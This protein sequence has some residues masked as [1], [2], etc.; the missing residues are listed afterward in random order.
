M[1]YQ[2]FPNAPGDSD[3]VAKL[4]ALQLG[5]L[6]GRSFLDVACNEGFF[7]QEAWRRGASRVVGIDSNPEFIERARRKDPDTDYRVMDWAN[8]SSLEET[9]DVI[10]LL[11]ALHYAAQPEKLLSDIVD[12]LHPDG[13]FILEC[14]V[15][16]PF[17]KSIE[18]ERPKWV[19]VQRAD[20]GVVHH[21]TSLMLKKVLEGPL[22][23]A[24]LR[25]I[26]PDTSS[27]VGFS[28]RT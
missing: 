3:S 9:F 16:P 4:A 11:S 20:G 25:E 8:L 13:V 17:V 26:G 6:T 28:G 21:P 2:S 7:C 22:K 27:T 5:D 24:A 14:G 23:R 19:K 10:L 18:V 1:P 12:L 15:A